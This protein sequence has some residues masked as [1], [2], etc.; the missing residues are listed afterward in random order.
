MSDQ[1]STSTS[2]AES[3]ASRE[4]THRT[5]RAT[6]I[7]L[8][9]HTACLG[10]TSLGERPRVVLVFAVLNVYFLWRLL[11]GPLRRAE[12]AIL[13][14]AF[15]FVIVTVAN[16][17]SALVALYAASAALQGVAISRL[18]ERERVE[19]FDLY[20]NLIALLC[21]VWLIHLRG[22]FFASR[23]EGGIKAWTS[24]KNLF[25]YAVSFAAIPV[26][27]SGHG[28]IVNVPRFPRFVRILIFAPVLV[29]S[30]SAGALAAAVLVTATW[31]LIRRQ[32]TRQRTLS[33]ATGAVVALIVGGLLVNF[34]SVADVLGRDST[35]TG[36]TVIWR[37]VLRSARSYSIV[38]SGVGVNWRGNGIG[39][40]S[41]APTALTQ[42]VW[43]ATGEFIT[44]THNSILELA[45]TL[46]IPLCIAAVAIYAASM[47]RLMRAPHGGRALMV[48]VFVGAAMLSES[49]AT[50]PL[51]LTLLTC[52]MTWQP[53]DFQ[54]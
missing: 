48:G 14:V 52:V 33:S 37:E 12:V 44:S 53:D 20:S 32:R 26:M 15:A 30:R 38:G 34:Q 27:W 18:Q 7:Q 3:V 31:L 22:D 2:D 19:I 43:T 50:V 4:Q 8:V 1:A 13:V 11:R 45:L 35:G 23:S 41:R 28:R 6:R 9:V 24:H 16:H 36:R 54:T 25:G 47:R 51:L 10:A 49:F 39:D 29:L 5:S 46:G 17:G 21:I 42:R 40:S